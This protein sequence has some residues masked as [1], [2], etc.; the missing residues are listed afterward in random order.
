[1][2]MTFLMRRRTTLLTA[3]FNRKLQT[4]LSPFLGSIAVPLLRHDEEHGIWKPHGEAPP[5][6]TARVAL[7]RARGHR[8]ARRWRKEGG[9]GRCRGCAA[10]RSR[11]SA[12]GRNGRAGVVR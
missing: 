7:L 2:L 5:A 12:T 9:A 10:G 4:S 1:M 11:R 8:T 6:L 3:E